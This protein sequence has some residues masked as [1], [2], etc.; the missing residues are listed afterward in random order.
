MDGQMVHAFDSVRTLCA[1]AAPCNRLMIGEGTAGETNNT[2]NHHHRWDSIHGNHLHCIH[3][4]HAWQGRNNGNHSWFHRTRVRR[5]QR[6]QWMSWWWA[7]EDERDVLSLHFPFD[8]GLCAMPRRTPLRAQ[9]YSH[10][11]EM[12]SIFE[13]SF[14]SRIREWKWRKMNRR[15]RTKN[16]SRI[17]AVTSNSSTPAHQRTRVCALIFRQSTHFGLRQSVR[18]QSWRTM[19]AIH[20]SSLINSTLWILWTVWTPSSQSRSK[21]VF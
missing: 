20:E 17:A 1:A 16:V 19:F 7:A 9:S 5:I 21:F 15:S 4:P 11:W 3:D 10:R 8:D 12:L 6:R 18:A 14:H 13:C 2:H